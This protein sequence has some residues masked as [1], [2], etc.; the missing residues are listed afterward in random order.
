MENRKLTTQEK[1]EIY[2]EMQ[3][4]YAVA[5]AERHLLSV[6][7]FGPYNQTLYCKDFQEKAGFSLDEAIDRRSPYYV[8]DALVE[9][10]F[11]AR[12]NDV[13]D[14]VTWEGVINGWFI[15]L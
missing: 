13:P 8:L 14:N 6:F 3:H 9:L 12:D 5:D 4:A 11:D 10:F 2:K 7:G 1:E 15:S